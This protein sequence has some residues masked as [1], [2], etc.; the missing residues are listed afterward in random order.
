[1]K[2]P[3]ART[4][5]RIGIHALP[6]PSC[7]QLLPHSQ[8]RTLPQPTQ[9]KHTC[10]LFTKTGG[11]RGFLPK[12]GKGKIYFDEI[13][14]AAGSFAPNR[15]TKTWFNFALIWPRSCAFVM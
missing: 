6:Q 12:T 15:S 8:N 7:F 2:S 10:A 9:N 11:Y 1:M 14:A 13:G 5:P 4:A 3:P